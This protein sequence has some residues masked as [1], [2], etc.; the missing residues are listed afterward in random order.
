MNIIYISNRIL[1]VI[2]VFCCTFALTKSN[3]LP[4]PSIS[5][6]V[7]KKLPVSLIIFSLFFLFL[8]ASLRKSDNNG[9]DTFF[10][11]THT[12]FVQNHQSQTVQ[13]IGEEMQPK[14]E[15]QISKESHVSDWFL[16]GIPAT[17]LY[18]L[19]G[20]GFCGSAVSVSLLPEIHFYDLY[21]W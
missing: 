21:C 6:V 1:S 2:S 19:N 13:L 9:K 12:G 5:T 4:N 20:A 7:R 17:V 10:P 11:G 14:E 15:R 16:S 8:N 3:M 18:P